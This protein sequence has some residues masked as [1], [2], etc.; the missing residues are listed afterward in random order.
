MNEKIINKEATIKKIKAKCKK[1]GSYFN[2]DAFNTNLNL[3]G[4]VFLVEAAALWE[5][6]VVFN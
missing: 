1:H 3:R 6:N 4:D 2:E 5:I